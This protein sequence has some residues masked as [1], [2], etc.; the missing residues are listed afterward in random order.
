[1]EHVL[2]SEVYGSITEELGNAYYLDSDYLD[3]AHH[4]GLQDFYQELKEQKMGCLYPEL[5]LQR[6]A[7]I[8]PESVTEENLSG[9]F[10]ETQNLKH[11]SKLIDYL[12]LKPE[13]KKSHHTDAKSQD[14]SQAAT[15]PKTTRSKFRF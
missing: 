1:M 14:C 7:S 6:W 4:L 10:K 12:D 13:Q 5:L 11:V 15:A 3:L 8:N 2:G 9:V